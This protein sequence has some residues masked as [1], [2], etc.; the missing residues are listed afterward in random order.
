MMTE[1]KAFMLP[2]ACNIAESERLYEAFHREAGDG[3]LCLDGS[4]VQVVDA[5]GLQ[6]LAALQKHLQSQGG[7]VEW[8]HVSE[9]LRAG[10]EDIGLAEFMG[11]PRS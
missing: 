8:L 9:R 3:R 6:L 5:T 1:A 10:L 7:Q 4:A 11:V 2:E